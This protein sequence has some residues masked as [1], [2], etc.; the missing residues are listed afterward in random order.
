MLDANGTIN[1]AI[2]VNRICNSW[3]GSF[4]A[5][6]AILGVVIAPITTG[7]T[8]L[9]CARLIL[10]DMLK[11][12]QDKV[13]KRIAICLP[14]FV[15][16]IILLFVKFDV[17]WR[18]FAWFNQTFSI[19]TFFTIAIYLAKLNKPY[20]LALLPGMFMVAV[21]VCYI[22]VDQY[23]LNLSWNLSYVISIACALLTG[24]WFM[25][26]KRKYLDNARPA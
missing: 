18:Y 20:Y 21:C 17:L 9:R 11:I 7:D 5:I 25:A 22:C 4:G 3:L 6:L 2:F 13:L 12:K 15:I 16:S 19:F 14:V 10:A 23:S 24:F 8:A 1:P 26:W